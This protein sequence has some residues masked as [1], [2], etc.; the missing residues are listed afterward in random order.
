M[1]KFINDAFFC[2]ISK[3]ALI[4]ILISK[5]SYP[6]SVY[7]INLPIFAH[8]DDSKAR[9]QAIVQKLD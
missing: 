1:I 9:R 8:S 4:P 2:A 6:Y 7:A 3:N 5:N